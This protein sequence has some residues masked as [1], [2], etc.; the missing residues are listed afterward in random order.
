[1]HPWIPWFTI[2]GRREVGP[3][4]CVFS[5][6]RAGISGCGGGSGIVSFRVW[7][8]GSGSRWV[9]VFI[10]AEGGG[11]IGVGVVDLLW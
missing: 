9:C 3:L 1:M 2:G 5:V 7:I 6:V 8:R 11:S 10:C 4:G